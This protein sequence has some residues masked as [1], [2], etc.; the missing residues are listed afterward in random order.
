MKSRRERAIE[1]KRGKSGK[2]SEKWGGGKRERESEAAEKEKERE[3]EREPLQGGFPEVTA[4]NITEECGMLNR[5][6][7]KHTG[8][9][10]AAPNGCQGLLYIHIKTHKHTVIYVHEH[11]YST[12]TQKA[13]CTLRLDRLRGTQPYM[14]LKKHLRC[15]HLHK[16]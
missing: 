8:R 6:Q 4:L 3:R 7:G 1:R 12:A 9:A 5:C 2:Q 14:Q 10:T 16:M 15:Q 11:I 13:Q